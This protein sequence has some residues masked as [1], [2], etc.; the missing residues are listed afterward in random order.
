MKWYKNPTVYIWIA[1]T[2]AIIV[3]LA[4]CANLN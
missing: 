1:I 2:I 3:L 4:G